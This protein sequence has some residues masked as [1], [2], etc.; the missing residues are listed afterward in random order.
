MPT[1]KTVKC[2]R[3]GFTGLVARMRETR[4]VY[5]ILAGNLLGN[6]RLE[7]RN[8]DETNV[9]EIDF[10]DLEWMELA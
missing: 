7:D 10:G 9:K 3:V 6:M 8:K 2:W 4:T 5:K 1:E